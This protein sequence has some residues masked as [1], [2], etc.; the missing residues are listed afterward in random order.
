MENENSNNHEKHENE[1]GVQFK[2]IGKSEKMAMNMAIPAAIVIAAI[3]IG[4][5]FL[6]SN[7]R[8]VVTK[9]I[10]QK[11]EIR[12]V[13][14]ND[15]ILGNPNAKIVLVEYSDTECPYCKQF[16]ATLQKLVA[17]YGQSGDLAWVYRHYPIAS[18]HPKSHHE[19]EATECA[20]ELGGP[21]KFWE[22]TDAVYNTTESNNKLD[23]AQLPV[24]AK[25]VGLDVTA[26]NT[27]LNSGKYASKVDVDIREA[28]AVGAD[29]TPYSVIITKDGTKT[30]LGGSVPFND[31]DGIITSILDK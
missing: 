15:H 10:T 28:Q 11:N 17:K 12:P 31:L 7:K 9:T 4:G 25:S 2:A 13:D 3:I 18:L 22:F 20:N 26:F 8:P 24:I 1:N 14:A 16:H 5:S 21:K 19:A 23:P 30:P 29:G 27:C 6:I